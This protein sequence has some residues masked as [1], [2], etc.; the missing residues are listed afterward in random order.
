M[1]FTIM[2]RL[3]PIPPDQD[4]PPEL[5]A[6]SRCQDQAVIVDA[7]QL[8]T[9]RQLPLCEYHWQIRCDIEED[10]TEEMVIEIIE[11]SGPP[12]EGCQRVA[13]RRLSFDERQLTLPL[14]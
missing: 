6:A 10:E 13:R 3:K 4:Y 12:P 9:S 2:L 14:A 7:T 1:I 5:C 11:R 8:L